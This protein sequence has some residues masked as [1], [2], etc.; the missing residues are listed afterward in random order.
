[1][2][3]L[4]DGNDEDIDQ[5]TVCRMQGKLTLRGQLRY[6]NDKDMIQGTACRMQ[7]AG[8]NDL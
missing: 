3:Q 8:N 4:R 1:M 7:D 5:G 6:G 2:G